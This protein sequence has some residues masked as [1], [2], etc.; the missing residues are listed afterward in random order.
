M[1]EVSFPDRR[2]V[3]AGVGE[4]V[5]VKADVG[6]TV[7]VGVGA[8]VSVKVGVGVTVG[9]GISVGVGVTVMEGAD[10]WGGS[11]EG[12]GV[13]VGVGVDAGVSVGVPSKVGEGRAVTVVVFGEGV[14]PSA[15]REGS[16]QQVRSAVHRASVSMA[17]TVFRIDEPP[18]FFRERSAFPAFPFGVSIYNSTH[19][20]KKVKR[21]FKKIQKKLKKPGRGGIT[22]LSVKK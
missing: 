13:S 19:F 9:V 20:F 18:F 5:S 3:S 12:V 14:C 1:F 11:G 22:A 21:F 10:V 4:G 15:G 7:G 6:V 2:T 8:G 16:V 17:E